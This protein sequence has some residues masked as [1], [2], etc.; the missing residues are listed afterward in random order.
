MVIAWMVCLRCAEAFSEKSTR[1]LF[2]QEQN[3][4]DSARRLRSVDDCKFSGHSTEFV[5]TSDKFDMWKRSGACYR[6]GAL[7]TP[8]MF[9][10]HG[11]SEKTA[12]Q[13]LVDCG[14]IELFS[15]CKDVFLAQ[16]D[17]K[18]AISRNSTCLP[19]WLNTASWVNRARLILVSHDVINNVLLSTSGDVGRALYDDLV[20]SECTVI[21][22]RKWNVFTRTFRIPIGTVFWAEQGNDFCI[23]LKVIFDAPS[24]PTAAPTAASIAARTMDEDEDVIPVP[25]KVVHYAV[26]GVVALVLILTGRCCCGFG[27]P[28]AISSV[29]MGST[30]GS[31]VGAPIDSVFLD[32]TLAS[33]RGS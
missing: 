3:T 15:R 6:Y 14:A 1:Q 11:T 18:V 32:S 19:H 25:K 5:A 26:G 7:D 12:L 10:T 23:D 20:Q 22:T 27:E 33:T 9:Q 29:S 28:R 4:G 21:S 24:A 17:I 2:R 8:W 31:Q 13:P 30:R 16:K